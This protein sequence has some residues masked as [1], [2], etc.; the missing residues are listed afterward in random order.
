[1]GPMINIWSERLSTYDI[2]Y[3][4]CQAIFEGITVHYD[5]RNISRL[6]QSFLGALNK[7]KL[8]KRFHRACLSLESKDSS[9]YS[10]NYR[11]QRN[12]DNAIEGFLNTSFSDK[13]AS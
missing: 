1:M 11:F 10:S 7:I 9:G 13:D 4:L 6:T 5:E 12:L 2:F 3:F 8:D